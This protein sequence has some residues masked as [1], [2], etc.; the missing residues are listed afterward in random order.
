MD[1][2][3]RVAP[4]RVFCTISQNRGCGGG[5]TPISTSSSDGVGGC[6]R[7]EGL[8]RRCMRDDDDDGTSMINLGGLRDGLAGAALILR[9]EDYLLS[10]LQ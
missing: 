8:E 1:I 5:G 9:D 2:V 4:L 6:G 3:G 10:H 7:G